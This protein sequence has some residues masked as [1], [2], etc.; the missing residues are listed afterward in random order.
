MSYLSNAESLGL[1]HSVDGKVSLPDVLNGIGAKIVYRPINLSAGL[2]SE[3]SYDK[4]GLVISLNPDYSNYEPRMNVIIAINIGHHFIHSQGGG[5]LFNHTKDTLRPEFMYWNRMLSEARSY[6]LSLL[7]PTQLLID[8]CVGYL[9]STE[10]PKKS[11]FIL[12][13]M[14][15]LNVPQAELLDRL[16]YAGIID[17]R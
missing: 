9:E 8:H 1:A 4:D 6:A 13:L 15:K 5:V 12:Y 7:M 11:D 3:M 17:L 14:G 2:V 16:A 10:S